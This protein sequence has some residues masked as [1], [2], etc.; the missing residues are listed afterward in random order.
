MESEDKRE[1]TQ[2]ATVIRGPK[3]NRKQPKVHKGR[4]AINYHSQT[5]R[6][7]NEI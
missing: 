2:H 6:N 1:E 4:N 3:P 5:H 7:T